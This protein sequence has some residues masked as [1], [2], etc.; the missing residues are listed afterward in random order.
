MTRRSLVKSPEDRAIYKGA[1]LH[2]A[3]IALPAAARSSSR[4]YA[5]RHNRTAPIAFHGESP[6][7]V[8]AKRRS[9]GSKCGS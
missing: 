2:Y 5:I 4:S 1:T 6:F 9:G 7:S 8:Y 3:T